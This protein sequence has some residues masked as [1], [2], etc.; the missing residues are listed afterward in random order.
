M[1]FE[2]ER[3][4]AQEVITSLNAQD[5]LLYDQEITWP[6]KMVTERLTDHIKNPIYSFSIHVI[7]DKSVNAFTIPDGH[8]FFNIGTILYAKDTDE[9]AAVIGHE[10]GHAQLRHIPQT[11]DEQKGVTAVSLLGVLLGALVS[12]RSPEAGTALVLSSLGGGE[13]IKLSYSRKHEYEADEFSNR[14]L[15]DSGFDPT[16]MNRFF[17]RLNNISAGNDIPEYLKTH[18]NAV[19]RISGQ[20]PD[21]GSPKPDTL[22]WSLGAS[23]IG[24]SLSEEEGKQRAQG[25]P[26]PYRGLSLGIL[27]T[28]K[29]RYEQALLILKEVDLPLAHAYR[30]IDLYHLGKK[31]EAYPLLKNYGTFARAQLILAEIL[32][33]KGE[34]K[35]ALETLLPYQKQSI[36]VDYKLGVLQ[37]KTS[38]LTQ[39]HVSFA[40]YFFKTAKYKA[41]IIHID[42]AL[43]EKKDLDETTQDELKQMKELAAKLAAK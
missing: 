12:S 19:N 20:S 34:F 15:K 33:E 7:N 30:G 42:K 5:A 2:E 39:A 9:I 40:R 14:L 41:C 23:V 21:T 25:L 27:E 18:P 29:G 16:A 43:E 38:Q 35:Q 8:I 4:I 6:I 22:F 28:R 32:E 37:E 3:K 13:N 24:L 10:I 1:T 31:E 11:M 26:E 17:V 36:Q